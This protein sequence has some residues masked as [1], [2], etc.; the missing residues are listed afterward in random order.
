MPIPSEPKVYLLCVENYRNAEST[1]DAEDYFVDGIVM[2]RM[3]L[4]PNQDRAALEAIMKQAL[5]QL[6]SPEAAEEVEKGF[7]KFH[8]IKQKGG[9]YWFHLMRQ[10]HKDNLPKDFHTNSFTEDELLGIAP[11]EDPDL[12]P[13]ELWFDRDG[14]PI[15]GPPDRLM[16]LLY[17]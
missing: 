2:L 13:K 16:G 17:S 4:D 7:P 8:A 12:L 14:D 10:E 9:L 3:P 11:A 15:E 6:Q 1:Y 5:V